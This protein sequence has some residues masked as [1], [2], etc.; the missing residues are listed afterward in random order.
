MTA[1]TESISASTSCPLRAGQSVDPAAFEKIRRALVLEH[2]KWDPQVGDQ[3]TLADF[4]L[5]I[6][7]GT[8]SQLAK[9]SQSLAA[10]LSAAEA[11]LIDRPNLHRR[12][13]MPYR[14]RRGLRRAVHSD[15]PRLARFDFHWTTDGWRISE[16]NADVPGGLCE[17]SDLCR[18]IADHCS[19]ADEPT[20][21]PGDPAGVWAAAI[22]AAATAPDIAVVSC[23]GFM[24]DH[25]V[26]AHL[27]ARIRQHALR[28]TSC[29]PANLRWC[30]GKAVSPLIDRPIGAIVRFVQAEWLPRWR[31]WTGLIESQTPVLNP[32][33]AALSE[34]KRLPLLWDTL[35][36][37]M[38]T[39]QRL[40][41]TTVDPRSICPG[42]EWIL[43]SAFCNT[44][45]SVSSPDW[46]PDT[47]WQKARRSARWFPGS[48]VAQRRFQTIAIPTPAGNRY[49]C[50]GVY[51]V[52]GRAAG[53]YGRLSC[54]PVIDFKAADVAVLVTKLRSGNRDD[55]SRRGV[56]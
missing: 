5:L 9:W 20:T 34:S 23:P 54:T 12:L 44:G 19:T 56:R 28:P 48:W 22:A 7:A 8:W 47:Q 26:M 10:E 41:P 50:V 38:P 3:P 40:L 37:P 39:W 32:V 18:L 49:P 52:N 11:E 27:S 24:E 53:I 43:K 1:V 15:S 55:A 16:A 51:T 45:D 6:D 35:N 30:E 29:G 14:L 13:G 4:P 31:G 46:L 2:A 25:Q 21:P 33:T 36:T 42:D 17:A